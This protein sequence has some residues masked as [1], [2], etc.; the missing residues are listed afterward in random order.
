MN[1]K[2]QIIDFLSTQSN[3][4]EILRENGF[5]LAIEFFGEENV[6]GSLNYPMPFSCDGDCYSTCHFSGKAFQYHLQQMI[7][8]PDPLAYMKNFIKETV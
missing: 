5:Q 2:Q 7:L 8:E 1:D 4:F 6:H 3:I